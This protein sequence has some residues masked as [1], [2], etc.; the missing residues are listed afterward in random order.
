MKIVPRDYQR[1]ALDAI[2][3]ELRERVS[4]LADMA[5]GTGKT[6][7]FAWLCLLLGGRVLV[8]VHRDELKRQAV[9]KILKVAPG[10]SIT[11]EQGEAKGDR[12]GERNLFSEG[13]SQIVIASKDTLS[14]P[15]RLARYKCD[16]F[17]FVIVDEAHH[18]VKR[19]DSYMNI[20]RHFCRGP[21]G[22]GIARLIGVSASLDRL[23]GEALGGVFQSVAYRYTI[24][25]AIRNGYLLEPRVKRLHLKGVKLAELPTSAKEGDL[26]FSALD[27]IMRTREYAYGIARPLLDLCEDGRQGAVFCSSG[28]AAQIQ[29]AILNAEKP[30]CAA[31]CLGEPYQ[32][33]A[34]RQSADWRMRRKEV[35]FLVSCDALIEG[36]DYDGCAV[37]VPKPSRSRQRIAQMVG[38]GTRPLDGCVDAWHTREDRLLAI[39]ASPKP[40]C[41]VLDP[42]GASEEHSLVNI[43]DIF[44]GRVSERKIRVPGNEE[45]PKPKD[46]EARRAMR[47]A[48]QMLEESAL[49]GLS[50]DV[51]YELV[52]SE[53]MSAPERKAGSVSRSA[54]AHPVTEPQARWLEANGYRVRPGMTKHEASAA[55]S[56]IKARLDA[57]PA[58][59]RQ[60]ALLRS[61][62]QNANVTRG[63]ARSVLDQLLRR[64][65]DGKA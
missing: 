50:V 23:D 42:C 17:D 27:R 44:D 12:R 25:E 24:A 37:V 10:A 1:E 36:W 26:T 29:A 49:S 58:S 38:R 35:Q 31:L 19:N 14:R 5:T 9:E 32:C 53:M 59:E 57:G 20:F 7:F 2:I 55:I 18:V 48:V 46:N 45:P 65:E 60:K 47:N 28:P 15:K 21:I 22:K 6:F 52:D 13:G 34:E 30:G 4:T 8:V 39:A 3:Y 16:D 64:G 54:L 40:Y 11:I 33:L 51:D 62:G 56:S 43:T 61:L 63:E 41:T